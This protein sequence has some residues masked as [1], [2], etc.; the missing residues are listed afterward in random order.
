MNFSAIPKNSLIGRILRFPLK[1]LPAEMILPILQGPSRGMRWIVGSG[2]HG[3]WLGSYE[4]GF[5][6]LFAQRISGGEIVFDIGAHVGFY[7]LLAARRV[8]PAGHVFAFEPLPRNADFIEQHIQ[9]NKLDNVTFQQV[10]ISDRSGIV[11]FGGGLSS[12]T[13]HI[14]TGGEEQVQAAALDN[15][16]D[17]G[18][19]DPPSVMKIDVE[20]AEGAVLRGGRELIAKHK[21]ELFLA[22]HGSE[23]Y[24]ECT[25]FLRSMKYSLQPINADHLDAATEIYAAPKGVP[26]AIG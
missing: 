16:L 8:G 26:T 13:G 17:S 21:P 7:T 19:I 3:Y 20:G 5:Q 18:K 15:L 1:L 12:S 9:I 10:A 22:M 23:A 6:K 2:D 4:I 11:R 14:T 25:A 24:Q